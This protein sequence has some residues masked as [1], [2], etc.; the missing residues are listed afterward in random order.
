MSDFLMII[1]PGWVEVPAEWV[2]VT[3]S[4]EE[5]QFWIVQ[6]AWEDLEP[7][8][9]EQGAVPVGQHLLNARLIQTDTGFRMWAM[10]G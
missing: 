10:F 8:L 3:N 4:L 5:I 1:P 9:S 6:E 2:G 7:I